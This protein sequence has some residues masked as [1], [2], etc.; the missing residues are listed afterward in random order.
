[1]IGKGCPKIYYK[2]YVLLCTDNKTHTPTQIP[3]THTHKNKHILQKG[4]IDGLCGE[5][6]HTQYTL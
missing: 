6:F 5:D 1:M 2:I 3:G 4:T